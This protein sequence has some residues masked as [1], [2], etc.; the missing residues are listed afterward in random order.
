MIACAP[1]CECRG[2]GWIWHRRTDGNVTHLIET[3]CP[4]LVERLT[5]ERYRCPVPA[6]VPAPVPVPVARPGQSSRPKPLTSEE[7]NRRLAELTRAIYPRGTRRKNTSPDVRP[8]AA[9]A[10]GAA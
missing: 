1:G 8:A 6:P 4:R 2:E 10:D 5:E 9:S 7:G 3:A